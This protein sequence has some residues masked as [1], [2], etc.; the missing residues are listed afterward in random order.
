MRSVEWGN[1]KAYFFKGSQYSRYDLKAD[2]VDPGYPK[3][4]TEWSGLP[5][6]DGV[7]AAVNWGNGKVLLFKGS[8]YVRIDVQA[9]RVD[10]GYPKPINNET[11]PGLP[12][13]DGIEAAINGGNGKIYLFK[14][15]Q[16]VRWD[17]QTDRAD[18]GYPKSIDNETWPGLSDLLR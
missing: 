2:R 17:I 11:W 18:P 12:W 5:W 6:T 8:Q 4:I 3:S 16:Y 14:E 15:T 10:P 9:D 13:T 1:G 7:D